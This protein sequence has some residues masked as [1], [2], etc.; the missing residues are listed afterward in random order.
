MLQHMCKRNNGCGFTIS[1]LLGVRVAND[2]Q[3]VQVSCAMCESWLV[4]YVHTG[5]VLPFG[6][7]LVNM[8]GS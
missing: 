1:E 6:N 4:C 7:F 5:P 8:Y 3:N 2:C